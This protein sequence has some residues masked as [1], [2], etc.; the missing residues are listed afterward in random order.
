MSE[1]TNPIPE[2]VI[3]VLGEVREIGAYNMF[4]RASVIKLMKKLDKDAGK[5]ME[6]NRN[7]YMDAL[8]EM[9]ERVRK[10]RES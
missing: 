4:D 7:R 3:V 9:G 2:N 8:N 1:N 5:W 6:E 10:S